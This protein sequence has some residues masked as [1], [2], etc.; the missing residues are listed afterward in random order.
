[1]KS[2][3]VLLC[4][5]A[6]ASNCFGGGLFYGGDWNAPHGMAHGFEFNDSDRIWDDFDIGPGG[7]RIEAA[8]GD[9]AYGPSTTLPLEARVDIRRGCAP[10]NPGEILLAGQFSC[11]LT[12]T[13][14]VQSQITEYRVRVSGL[15][16]QLP[17]GRYWLNV[18]PGTYGGALSATQG[19]NAVGSPIMNY[20]AFHQSYFWTQNQFLPMTGIYDNFSYGVE[21]TPVPEPA[22][23]LLFAC[24]IPLLRRRQESK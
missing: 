4:S 3:V 19:S 10:G 24:L 22:G 20:N 11:S 7:A 16:I 1:M 21:G 6:S 18:W 5:L 2:L 17:E 8:F 13:G 15:D 12:P 23:I 14:R 9:H